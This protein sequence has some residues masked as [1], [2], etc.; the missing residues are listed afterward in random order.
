MTL[1]KSNSQNRTVEKD[2]FP[3]KD[4][5]FAVVMYGGG[6]LAIYMNGVAQELYKMVRAT[7]RNSSG[8]YSI[9]NPQ[10]TEVVYR[11]LGETLRA[12]F[13]VDILSGTSAGGINA[14][15]LAKALANNQ[16]ME[17]LEELWIKEGNIR[18]LINDSRSIKDRETKKAIQGLQFY[19]P[20]KTL[21]NT[22]RM[23]YI[24]LSA[25]TGMERD[26][27]TPKDTP[28]SLVDELDLYVTATDLR[29]IS[30]PIPVVNAKILEYRYRTV[31]RIR[32]ATK[33]ADGEPVT[34]LERESNP[35]LAFAARAT[36]AF[37]LVFQPI[38][39]TDNKSILDTD[40][41]KDYP[42]YSRKWN[43]FHRDY[44]PDT[45]MLR[46]FADGGYLDNKP[47]SY[48]TETLLRRQA[49]LP[50]DRKLFYV[51]PAPEKNPSDDNGRPNVVET[52]Q[53]SLKG[54][55]SNRNNSKDD[56]PDPFEALLDG[57]TLPRAE[58]IREDLLQIMARNDKIKRTNNIFR[59]IEDGTGDIRS[60]V[61]KEAGKGWSSRYLDEML[62]DESKLYSP[63]YAAY[64]QLKVA[65]TLDHF[66][67]AV[68][69]NIGLDEESQ[70]FYS[71]RQ[72]FEEWRRRKYSSNS[73]N[74]NRLPSENELLFHLDVNWRKRR[75]YF[76]LRTIDDLLLGLN[77][78]R[79]DREPAVPTTKEQNRQKEQ[80]QQIH[81]Q[82]IVQNSLKPDE[83]MWLIPDQKTEDQ[84]FKI[85]SEMKQS[86]NHA[87]VLLRAKDRQ[88]RARNVVAIASDSK[89][90]REDPKLDTYVQHIQ[91]YLQPFVNIT[92]KLEGIL[93]DKHELELTVEAIETLSRTLSSKRD[94]ADGESLNFLH[95]TFREVADQSKAVLGIPKKADEPPPARRNTPKGNIQACLRFYYENFEYFD[96]LTF[97]VVYATPIGE[98][99]VVEVCRISPV[100]ASVLYVEQEDKPKLAGTKIGNFGGFFKE[101]WRR[102]DI[103]W[104]QLDA[105]ESIITTLLPDAKE[106]DSPDWKTYQELLV[107]AWLAILKDKQKT[108]SSK[109]FD[110]LQDCIKNLK[111][112]QNAPK[113]VW[114]EFQSSQD[115]SPD[116]LMNLKDLLRNYF[117]SKYQINR[118]SFFPIVKA[119]PRLFIALVALIISL[120]TKYF[121]APWQ[122]WFWPA[123][124]IGVVILVV[125]IFQ[126]VNPSLFPGFDK[127]L[128]S[129]GVISLLVIVTINLIVQYYA[130]D[131]SA[132]SD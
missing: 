119:L 82:R 33:A 107:R 29:G 23:Y 44:D 68:A 7:A 36:S 27:Q 114:D 42:K 60:E 5:R 80:D 99:D 109:N 62:A 47:F 38:K 124:I 48:I 67:S 39:I 73:T 75:L 98:S 74:R 128:L 76:V 84:Y 115:F 90:F 77:G 13:V 15:Y 105:A 129:I 34:G 3:K 52:P 100:D 46:S 32:H 25:L 127:N 50:V 55:N 43:D 57:L 113:S 58:T 41:F 121:I 65:D 45:F 95:E 6:S 118:S 63:S 8:G 22:G 64:H 102:N 88:F 19:P 66:A 83:K 69:S 70:S 78:L 101:E 94:S 37:P 79:N 120:I 91:P 14:I 35:F 116:E 12:R 28:P 56:R 2:L 31:F 24:L 126:A 86:L 130:R 112:P 53:T 49:D 4:I 30:L 132:S 51:E 93:D 104:G 40:T 106:P 97:P 92:N 72:I 110:K 9:T 87:R 111:R 117:R 103:L 1:Q 17:K 16:S 123:Y 20:P 96:S 108:L 26:A 10:G 11:A 122:G 71:L 85:L 59:Q 54:K 18:K 131:T 21:L 61:W 89:E 81:A 125:G